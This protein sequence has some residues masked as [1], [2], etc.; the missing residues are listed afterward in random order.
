MKRTR[1]SRDRTSGA[2]RTLCRSLRRLR[3]EWWARALTGLVLSLAGVA[4]LVGGVG[5]ANTMVVG[6]ME[7]RGELGLRRALGARGGQIAV[8]ILLETVLMGFIGGIGG[9]VVGGVAVHG[10]ALAQG[11]PPSVPLCTIVAGPAVSVPVA[12]AGIYPALRAA[13]ASPT[14]AL[15]SA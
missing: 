1:R 15:R 4:L 12:A 14:D 5:I 6:V 3:R 7:R 8:Q 2:L 13:R 10:Y 11:W 9:L